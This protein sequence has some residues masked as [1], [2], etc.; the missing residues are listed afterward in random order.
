MRDSVNNIGGSLTFSINP[1]LHEGRFPNHLKR[2]H[3]VTI[4]ESGDIEDPTNYR[5]ISITFALSKPFEKVIQNE[6]IE[7]LDDTKLLSPHQ[8]GFG[9]NFSTA[10][11]LLYATEKIL[12]DIDNKKV[13]ATAF[14]DLSKAFDSISHEILLHIL[15]NLNFTE[16]SI[17]MIR[18]FLKQRL[19][20]VVLE[21]FSDWIE[22]Y[23]GVPQGTI[24]GPLLF[25]TYVNSMRYSVSKPCELVQ[26]ADETFIFVSGKK[27]EDA[28]YLLEKRKML[29]WFFP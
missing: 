12:F 20:E 16:N 2:A 10:D 1:F 5:P 29:S 6:N 18:S 13:A 22:L 7:F 9:A 28:I 3:V 21:T 15:H 19:Q 14:L 11:A 8:F 25:N 23:Q 26:Y 27:I 24:L 17:A 4:Y